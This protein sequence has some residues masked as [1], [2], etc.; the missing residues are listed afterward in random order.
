MANDTSFRPSSVL[1]VGDRLTY[2]NVTTPHFSMFVIGVVP[3]VVVV[4]VSV[5]FVVFFVCVAFWFWVFVVLGIVNGDCSFCRQR[6][7]C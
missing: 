2:T 4:V 7:G 6:R 3:V 1:F 5:V